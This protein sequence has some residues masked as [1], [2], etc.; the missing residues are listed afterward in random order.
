MGFLTVT[1]HEGKEIWS[2]KCLKFSTTLRQATEK[3]KVVWALR[4][5]LFIVA[6][7]GKCTER[8][9][10]KNNRKPNSASVLLLIYFQISFQ[11][12]FCG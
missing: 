8:G 2:V 5:L 4:V 1:S 11:D 9:T 10:V 3:E 6:N 7:T 12:L